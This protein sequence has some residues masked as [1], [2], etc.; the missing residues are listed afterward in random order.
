MATRTFAGSSCVGP[1]PLER[2]TSER[3]AGGDLTLCATRLVLALQAGWDR[4]RQLTSIAGRF[5]GCVPGRNP[6][7]SAEA[8]VLLSIS[9]TRVPYEPS[10][11]TT[12]GRTEDSL[13]AGRLSCLCGAIGGHSHM[14]PSTLLFSAAEPAGKYPV[15]YGWSF[16]VPPPDEPEVPSKPESVVRVGPPQAEGSVRDRRLAVAG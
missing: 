13:P 3:A 12:S 14:S 5:G 10:V 9:R 15:E 8:A 11:A 16:P 2:G 6:P 7:G 4:P 1:E